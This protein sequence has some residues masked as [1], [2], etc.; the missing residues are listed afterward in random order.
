MTRPDEIERILVVTDEG[1]GIAAIKLRNYIQSLE[2]TVDGLEDQ[3]AE[4]RD[5]M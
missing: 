5:A 1:W 4:V 2:E 3:L